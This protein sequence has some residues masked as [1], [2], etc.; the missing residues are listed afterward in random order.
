M[1]NSSQ[2]EFY[3][4]AIDVVFIA[5]VFMPL[6]SLFFAS[7]LADAII[8][9]LNQLFMLMLILAF[10]TAK[11]SSNIKE[12]LSELFGLRLPN[13]TD[14]KYVII[15]EILILPVIILIIF[16]EERLTENIGGI[17]PPYFVTIF[18]ESSY[19]GK[20]LL[21]F[22][23]IVLAPISEEIIF[24]QI[25][26]NYFKEVLLLNSVFSCFI[27]ATIFAIV[28]TEPAYMLAIFMLGIAFQ[29]LAIQR[30]SIIASMMM[31][32]LHNGLAISAL[33]LFK[34]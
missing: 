14:I 8:V 22:S 17:S 33:L 34:T 10:A 2:K 23:A 28:H 32:S 5:F 20:L 30:K 13:L 24:R 1:I 7:F 4:I 29:V 21:C 9:S 31:H 27:S 25:I 6:I 19:I 15:A 12:I 18:K 16:I 11:S 3:K 26:F